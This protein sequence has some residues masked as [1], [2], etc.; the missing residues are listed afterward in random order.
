MLMP[1][2]SNN[3]SSP[4]KLLLGEFWNNHPVQSSISPCYEDH[5]GPCIRILEKALAEIRSEMSIA[6]VLKNIHKQQDPCI[7]AGGNHY[8][9]SL[10]FIVQNL[11]LFRMVIKTGCFDLSVKS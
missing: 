5:H 3:P 11:L 1:R 9:R 4:K 10:F 7:A 8:E 6:A 2:F